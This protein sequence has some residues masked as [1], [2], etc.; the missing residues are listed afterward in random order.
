SSDLDRRT[1]A[2]QTSKGLRRWMLLR[3]TRPPPD[4]LVDGAARG[5][6]GA[7]Q[8]QGGGGE[9]GGLL[10]DQAAGFAVGLD[11]GLLN[12]RDCGIQF[13][14]ISG[15]DRDQ[16]GHPQY[17]VPGGEVGFLL[18]RKSTRLNSSHV[19]ISYAGF[20]LK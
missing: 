16:S 8:R 17:P 1:W 9:G 4:V 19:S 3:Y 12:R 15:G 6:D 10:A 7:T 18:D 13:L 5:L 14:R 20:C 11:R 2:S